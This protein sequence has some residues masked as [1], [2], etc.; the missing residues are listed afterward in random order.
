VRA[1]LAQLPLPARSAVWGAAALG[2]LGC[3][4]GLVV[5]LL[6]HAPTAW[7]ATAEVGLPSAFVGAVAGLAAGSVRAWLLRRRDPSTH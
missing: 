7:A 3:G 5:G 4:V 6:V 2:V 1:W